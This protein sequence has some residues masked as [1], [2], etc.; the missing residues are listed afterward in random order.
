VTLN[1]DVKVTGLLLMP[2]TYCVRA[3]C[4]R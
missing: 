3:I 4:L 1:L 2:S